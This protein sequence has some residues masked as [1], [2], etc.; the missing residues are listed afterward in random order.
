MRFL[1]RYDGEVS[2]SLVG[3]QGSRVSMRMARGTAA[4]CQAP[5]SMGFPGKS[6]GVGCH[7]GPP[8]I[9]C[10]QVAGSDFFRIKENEP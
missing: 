1:P 5:P 4:A 9:L 3:R 6:T 8:K 2:E 10:L 7:R